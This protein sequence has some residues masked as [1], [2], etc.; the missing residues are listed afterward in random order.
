MVVKELGGRRNLEDRGTGGM[1][2]QEEPY[3]INSY[4]KNLYP[5]S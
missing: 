1:G 3:L 4:I 2:N 5:K